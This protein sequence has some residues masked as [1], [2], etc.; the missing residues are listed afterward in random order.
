MT[1]AA[2][3]SGR[4]RH[5]IQKLAQAP[6]Q[7]EI[8]GGCWRLGRRIFVDRGKDGLV[9]FERAI[10]DKSRWDGGICLADYSLGGLSRV[11]SI[12]CGVCMVH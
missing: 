1:V 12:S 7:P 9:R 8:L 6:D 10:F 5:F 2:S 11:H 4:L 3:C